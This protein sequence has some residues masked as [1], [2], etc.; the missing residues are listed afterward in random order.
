MHAVP[1]EC[2]RETRLVS[3]P[4]VDLQGQQDPH[5]N[6]IGMLFLNTIHPAKTLHVIKLEGGS[7]LVA[8]KTLLTLTWSFR[9]VAHCYANSDENRQSTTK[10]RT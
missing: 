9:P 6:I 3:Q 4:V 7:P 5:A 8:C 10:V 1:S 2:N